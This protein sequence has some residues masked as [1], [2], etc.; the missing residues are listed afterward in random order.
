MSSASY[1]AEKWLWA[2]TC[3]WFQGSHSDR[4][5]RGASEDHLGRQQQTALCCHGQAWDPF[6]VHAG[7][8][9]QDRALKGRLKED[10]A[11]V[12]LLVGDLFHC[13]VQFALPFPD[14]LALVALP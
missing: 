5:V 8:L 3:H 9:N 11:F 2:K 10:P 12:K 4:V 14:Q 6:V 13:M 7:E 1:R